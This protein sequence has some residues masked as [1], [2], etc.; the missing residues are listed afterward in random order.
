MSHSQFSQPLKDPLPQGAWANV[1]EPHVGLLLLTILVMMTMSAYFSGSE[2]AMMRL[3]RYRL[4]HF[5]KDGHRGAK[6]VSQL[7]QRPDRLLGVILL[8]NNLVNFIAASCATVIAGRYLGEQAAAIVAPVVL[9]IMFLILAEVT[10]KTLAEQRPEMVAFPSS[11]VLQPLLKACSPLVAMINA[12]GNGIARALTRSAKAEPEELSADELRT[13]VDERAALPRE[14]QDM[15]LGILDLE[16]ATV[17]DIMVPRSKIVGIDLTESASEIAAVI[18][19]S[20]HTRLP[21]W[22][23]NVNDMVGVLHLRRAPR[24]LSGQNF[25]KDDLAQEVEEPYFVPESTPLPAQLFNFQKEKQRVALAVDEYGDVQGIVTLEDILEEIVGEFTTNVA[26]EL[27]EPYPQ[28]DGAYIVEGA[29]LL[30]DVNRKLN[31]ELPTAGPRTLNG[32]VLEHLEFI[33][34][35]NV[36]LQVGRYRIET[37]QLADNVVRAAKVREWPATSS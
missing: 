30:R 12:V 6:K 4:R 18:R 33:P 26:D 29:A 7:L 14:R 25:T 10:P 16:K 24:L 15:L 23:E 13:V 22:R 34:E 35:A 31:W 1:N 8:G 21:V 36:C 20:Q 19:S 11:Y 17:N 3:N 37:L 28:K 27:A 9:T 2:T 5:V 32:L